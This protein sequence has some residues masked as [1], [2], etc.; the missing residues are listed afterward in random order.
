MSLPLTG[1]R[2]V[3][4]AVNLPGPVAAARLASMGAAVTKVE[5]PT[6][7]PTAVA[8]ELYAELV[9]GQE[10]VVLDLKDPAELD[11]LHALLA[12]AD[13]FLTSHRTAALERLGLGWEALHAR[14]PRLV[15]V[16]IVGHPAPHDDVPGH[17]LTY[18]AVNGMLAAP[19]GEQPRMPTVLV[20]DFAGAE[21]AVSA[22]LAALVGR[23]SSGV[24]TR[25]EVAL[26]DAAAAMALPLR[27]GM[28]RPGGILN[29]AHPGYGIYPSADGHV[30]VGALEPHFLQRLLDG[31]GVGPD[32]VALG[33]TFVTR[34]SEDWVAWGREH[35][36]PIEA[37]AKP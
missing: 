28:T 29:G 27:H 23:G 18:Q 2:V 4:I 13:V 6:G 25:V 9:A 14:H 26:S 31:L 36:V 15:H 12:E 7:D 5:P 8:P 19:V 32:A 30:A 3:S 33:A 11:R 16:A 20:A 35:D 1:V 10:V 22:A 37:I 24:G 34:P 21:W 17:D